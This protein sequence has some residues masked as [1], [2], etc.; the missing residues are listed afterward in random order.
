MCFYRQSYNRELKEIG[1]K[2]KRNP[3]IF[4]TP[5]NKRLK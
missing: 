3:A 1:T 4:T 5:T 2:Y